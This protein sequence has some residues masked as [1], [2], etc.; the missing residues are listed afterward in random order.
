MYIMN[1]DYLF[2]CPEHRAIYL[3]ALKL[4]C[5]LSPIWSTFNLVADKKW[6]L[7]PLRQSFRTVELITHLRLVSRLMRG[8]IPPLPRT[9]SWCDPSL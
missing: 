1:Y 2:N 6:D 5:D 9:F 8:V 3:Q 7:F 4:A